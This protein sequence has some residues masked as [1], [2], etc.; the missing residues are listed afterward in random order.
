MLLKNRSSSYFFFISSSSIDT[1]SLIY[2]FVD[3]LPSYSWLNPYFPLILLNDPFLFFSPIII[4]KNVFGF[5]SPYW[6][7]QSNDFVLD[8]WIKERTSWDFYF[9]CISRNIL[10]SGF[11]YYFIFFLVFHYLLYLYFPISVFK[12]SNYQ[13]IK[14]LL[15]FLS[16]FD[17]LFPINGLAEIININ[18]FECNNRKD[19]YKNSWFPHNLMIKPEWFSRTM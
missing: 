16:R 7:G 11:N 1:M 6:V 19:C 15:L 13:T 14:T 4:D 3:F 10:L 2:S 8:Y 9:I 17:E 5:L 12:R 18:Y